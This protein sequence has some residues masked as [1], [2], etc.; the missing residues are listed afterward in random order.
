MDD[1]LYSH[2]LSGRQCVDNV[3]RNYILITPGSVR[4]DVLFSREGLLQENS[5]VEQN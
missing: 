4:V 5:N 3:R 1:F 2:H